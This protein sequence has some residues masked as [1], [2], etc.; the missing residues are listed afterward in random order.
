MYIYIYMYVC[1]YVYIYM[2]IYFHNVI[3]LL[4]ALGNQLV[5]FILGKK[6]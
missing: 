6:Y 4:L 3:K 2:Y 5:F 1:M